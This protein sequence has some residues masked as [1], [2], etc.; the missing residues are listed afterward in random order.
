M[1]SNKLGYQATKS[2]QILLASLVEK[3]SVNEVI[4]IHHVADLPH[5]LQLEVEFRCPINGIKFE[6]IIIK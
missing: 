4:V 5:I 3:R 1:S 6:R 2:Q